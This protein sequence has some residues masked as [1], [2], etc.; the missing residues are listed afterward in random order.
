M[1]APTSDARRERNLAAVRGMLA[2]VSAGDAQGYLAHVADDVVYEAPWYAN[3]PEMRGRA[4]LAGMLAAVHQRFSSVR[5]EI[6]DHF[7][8]LDPDLVIV[9]LRGD[10]QVAGSDARYRNHYLMFVRFRDGRVAHWREFSNPD[11]YRRATGEG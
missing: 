7:P 8:T 9:E 10:N 4:A 11:V 2:A 6:V 1:Q 5:Y 3:F